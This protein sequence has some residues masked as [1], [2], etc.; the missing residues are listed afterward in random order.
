M[1]HIPCR[2]F[3]ILAREAP[4]A[5][6]FRRGPSKQCELIQWNTQ[7][8]EIRRGQWFRGR[9]YERRCD[10]SPDGEL[11]IYFA[12]NGAWESETR[13]AWT[14]ISK[15]PYFTAL[16]L[17]PKGDCWQGGGLFI[18]NKTVFLNQFCGCAKP[19]KGKEAKRLRIVHDHPHSRMGNAEC[20]GIYYP[21]LLR[22]GWRPAETAQSRG[23][24]ASHTWDR[25]Q[26]EGTTCLRKICISTIHHPPGRGC[27]YDRYEL[28][29]PEATIPMP[30]T[31]W[32]DWDHAGRLV[33]ARGG[34]LWYA[35]IHGDRL[36]ENVIADFD[37]DH[38]RQV[39]PPDWAQTW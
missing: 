7:T 2:L 37:Q 36:E 39:V 17:W 8:D 22:D 33:F 1:R 23:E 13:G 25:D 9:I 28:I 31:E 18:D 4:L 30:E 16:A 5:V 21:R 35:Q 3:A 27:Y 38:P 34:K 15:P 11:L 14:A 10:L 12:M 20:L 32:A 24:H 29:T 26:R 19:L 6:I